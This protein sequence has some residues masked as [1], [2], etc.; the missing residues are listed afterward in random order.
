MIQFKGV[1]YRYS[2]NPSETTLSRHESY[3]Y[4]SLNE[5]EFRLGL[6]IIFVD[7]TFFVSVL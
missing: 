6:C 1:Q 2:V 7:I 5:S 4:V 3:E